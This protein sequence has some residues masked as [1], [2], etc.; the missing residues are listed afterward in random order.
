MG[1]K[2]GKNIKTDVEHEF[3]KKDRLS[4]GEF[5][6]KAGNYISN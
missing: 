6:A 3:R 4:C 5:P 1:K 2:D